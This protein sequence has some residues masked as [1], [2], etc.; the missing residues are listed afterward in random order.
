MTGSVDVLILGSGFGG[1]LLSLILAKSGRRVA[2][3]DRESHPRFAIGESSTPLADATLSMLA[4]RYDLPD[5][6]PLTKYGTWKREFP[7][8]MCGAKRGF[9]YFGHKPQQAFDEA[10]Q[11]LVAASTSNDS[12]DT[13]WLR[14]DI[15]HLFFQMAGTLGVLQ[16]QNAQYKLLSSDSQWQ[17]VS[18]RDGGEFHV[19]APFVVDATGGSGAVL[20][21]LGVANQTELLTTNSAAVFAH[22]QNVVPVEQMLSNAGLATNRHPFPCDSA[23]VHHVLDDGWMWQLR[24]DDDTVSAGFVVDRNRASLPTSPME[25]W[26]RQLQRFPFL[27]AQFADAKVIRPTDGLRMSGRLQRLTTQAAGRNWAALPNT[28]GFIDPLHS[29]GI[30]HTLFGVKC[31]AHILLADLSATSRHARLEE[32]SAQ[33]IDEIRLIDALVEGCYAALP[34]FPLWCDWCML[35]FAAVTSM[36]QTADGSGEAFLRAT[37]KDF[38]RVVLDARSQLQ[39]AIEEGRSESACRRFRDWLRITIAPWNHVGLLDDRCEGMYAKTAAPG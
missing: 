31:L 7:E 29:T 15:D 5:L 12:S 24:F 37:D 11:L 33:T 39:L 27:Q 35:Y 9:S 13:H 32:F 10:H 17:A 21:Y 30:A 18:T 20:R 14:S 38:R 28:A 23:A 36:E 16:F 6:K 22:F 34:S 4:E 1:S 3:I 19:T 2:V 25:I 8:V 26:E